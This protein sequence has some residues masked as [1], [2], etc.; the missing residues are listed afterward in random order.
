MLDIGPLFLA[1]IHKE[2]QCVELISSDSIPYL[3]EN[4]IERTAGVVD[5]RV[6]LEQ[7]NNLTSSAT[8]AVVQQINT[9]EVDYYSECGQD[10][11]NKFVVLLNEAQY[12]VRPTGLY[13]AQLE[14]NETIEIP[15]Y[16]TR[17]G[18]PAENV[19][20]GVNVAS[21]P[22][23]KNGVTVEDS[24]QTMKTTNSSGL[25]TF[26]Y[27][28]AMEM[29]TERYYDPSPCEGN[30]PKLTKLPI[31]GQVYH[32][33]YGVCTTETNCSFESENIVIK[34]LTSNNAPEP[35]T[36]ERDIYP[37]FQQHYR[38]FVVMRGILN[39]SDYD[40]V[41]T[42]QNLNLL[43]YSMSLDITDPN[44]MPVTRD[45]SPSKQQMILD[46]LDNPI[47][48]V[49]QMSFTTPDFGVNIYDHTPE[50][51]PYPVCNPTSVERD[52][53]V[54]SYCEDDSIGFG[55]CD[56]LG[57]ISDSLDNSVTNCTRPLFGY[58]KN[59]QNPNIQAL[60]TIENLQEQ[61]QQA[62]EL[63]FATIPLYLTSLYSIVDGCNS[64][65]YDLIRS[66]VIQEMLHMVQAANILI[67][68][69]GTP[70][71]DNAS[72]VPTFPGRLP[73]CVHPNLMVYL[74][75]LNISH[76]H[77]VF[78][79]L[80]APNITCVSTPVPLL[81]NHTI[82]QFYYEIG[83]CI[84]TLGDS[85]FQPEKE[86]LQVNWPWPL[87]N[88]SRVG[89]VYIVTNMATAVDGINE[90]IEQGE[91]TD[92]LQPDDLVA[93]QLSHYYRFQEIVCGRR[94]IRVSDN[95]Y[96]YRGDDISFDPIGVW[97]MRQ[98]PGGERIM[99]GTNC[100]TEATAF[101][102]VFRALLRELQTTFGGNPSNIFNSIEL[103]E[104]LR[105]HAKRVMRVK[106]D[107]SEETCGPVW[108]YDFQVQ[109]VI[110]ETE[111]RDDTDVPIWYYLVPVGVLVLLIFLV[112]VAL[113][114]ACFCV[115][116]KAK[117]SHTTSEPDKEMHEL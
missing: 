102:G 27:R 94:L 55:N 3:S 83:D 26:T 43:R 4:W 115:K 67:A 13:R 66:V 45:I 18:K 70:I 106:F 31:D 25:V 75:K 93:G 30:Q 33:N 65:I 64:E 90:I 20:I 78:T 7:L 95:E 88:N 40:S 15:L 50:L 29:G 87:Q 99:L 100:Y 57:D 17:L 112:S 81:S 48:N 104:S 5:Y 39:L 96:A 73:G 23:P 32:F 9:S 80:E 79:I 37:I 110:E 16:V 51:V 11:D 52:F 86:E 61:L 14:Y 44:Y 58:T 34:G 1:I 36:W 28:V 54:P 109:E 42:Y 47:R 71:V 49:T 82:G 46:W 103:M 84:K 113:L 12:Y 41:T 62:V 89:T 38:L 8:L 56:H 74:D 35:Y 63:E 85:I 10:E 72:F 68:T 98:S 116:T 24:N 117:S 22:K 60:C 111:T 19:L 108:D 69:G 92:P 21:N 105:L 76:V 77:D 2:K 6:S 97:P 59:S 101:H 114:G 53:D 91:G 107:D